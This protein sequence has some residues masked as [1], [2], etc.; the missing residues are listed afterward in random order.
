MPQTS[1]TCPSCDA[2]LKLSGTPGKSVK[3]PRCGKA[4]NVPVPESPSKA[5]KAPA[6]REEDETETDMAAWQDQAAPRKG[7]EIEPQTDL[8]PVLRGAAETSRAE[9][10]DGPDEKQ[11]PGSPVLLFVGLG[12]VLLLLIVVLVAVFLWPR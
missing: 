5:T 1:L 9:D 3:C 4:F 2:R 8:M 6:S 11:K 7:R 12:A 10:Q